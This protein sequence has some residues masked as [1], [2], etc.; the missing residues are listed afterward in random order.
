MDAKDIERHGR[1]LTK[2]VAQG[3]SADV[4]LK[5]LTDL[6][7]GVRASED[8]LRSTKIGITV[9]KLKTH[10]DA[11][12][13]RQASDLVQQWKK[14]INKS[15]GAS[16]DKSPKTAAAPNGGANAD[17]KPSG[18]NGATAGP[19][20]VDSTGNAG[21]EIKVPPEKRNAKADGVDT[22]KTGNDTRDMSVKLLYDG[23]AFMSEQRKSFFLAI[24]R[25]T[26]AQVSFNILF[27]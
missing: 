27:D 25:S 9:N 13:A 12:V 20:Q 5:F 15:G 10:K 23:L 1:D 26:R 18:A 22:R 8:L 11:R 17:S 14:D 4:L 19:M 24:A 3:E 21:D 2:A 7:S 16:N 6:R